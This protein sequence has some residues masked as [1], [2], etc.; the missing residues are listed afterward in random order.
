MCETKENEKIEIKMENL[1]LKVKR[2]YCSD[3]LLLSKTGRSVHLEVEPSMTFD[4]IIV[5]SAPRFQPCSL[6]R[7]NLL[8][9]TS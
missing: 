2:R 6:A 9:S 5:F 3:E 7:V 4:T 8:T 1:L